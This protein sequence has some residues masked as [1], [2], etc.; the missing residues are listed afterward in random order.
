M[1]FISVRSLLRC[2]GFSGMLTILGCSSLP[3]VI[4]A[5]DFE[6]ARRDFNWEIGGSELIEITAKG[7]ARSVYV[8]S[9]LER[10]P[11]DPPDARGRTEQEVLVPHWFEARWTPSPDQL[12]ELQTLIDDE[13]ILALED[14][15]VDDD[16]SDGWSRTYTL[17]ALGRTKE[18]TCTNDAP[19][20]LEDLDALLLRLIPH[21]GRGPIAGERELSR[22]E[23]VAADLVQR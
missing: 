15:Y 3:S 5:D 13:R 18:I 11:I 9:E 8:R 22:D 19:G 1:S 20:S 7:G 16:V 17:R 14:R 21:T 12:R 2:L 4:D 23:L 6:L 10:W